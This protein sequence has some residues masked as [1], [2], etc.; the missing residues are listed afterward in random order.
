MLSENIKNL[1]K[2]KGLTQEELAIRLN[3]VR[4]TISKWEKGTS[5]PDVD[6]VEKLAS[7]LDTDVSTLLGKTI[8]LNND[9][10]QI[11]DQL[12]RISEQLAVKNRRWR[13]F[14]KIF[15]ITVAAIILLNLLLAFAGGY[16]F[17]TITEKQDAPSR[18]E[19]ME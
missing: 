18:T 13:T 5:V 15:G 1:R 6:L 11:A 3:V 12:A 4:Q 9:T 16:A 10:T 8:T 14:W 17:Q 19:R 2:Q 7:I